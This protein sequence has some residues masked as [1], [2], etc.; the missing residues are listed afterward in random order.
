MRL[1]KKFAAV[2]GAACL[3]LAG[4]A[5]CSGSKEAQESK[6]EPLGEKVAEATVGGCPVILWENGT[7]EFTCSEMTINNGGG[8]AL[9]EGDLQYRIEEIKRVKSGPIKVSG[10][11][12]DLFRG[13]RNLSDISDLKNWDVSDVTYMGDVFSYTNIS[14]VDALANWDVSKVENM[15]SMFTETGIKSVDALAKWDTS[16]VT[17][18]MWM[19]VG[20]NIKSV[21]DLP[22]W[23]LSN[24]THSTKQIFSEEW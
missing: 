16:N 19:F 13:A 14:S 6:E 7:L 10:S 22:N 24:L 12:G 4:L 23:D 1:G 17:F 21:D 15:R 2:F 5:G 3:T 8:L 9:S 18:M 11:L 20:T